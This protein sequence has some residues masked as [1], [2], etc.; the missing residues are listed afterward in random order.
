MVQVEIIRVGAL[1]TNCYVVYSD[2]SAGCVLIDPGG[3]AELISEFM[4]RQEL[5]PERIIS[6]HAHAD[7][8]GAVA[9]LV[10]RYQCKFGLGA[11]D[12]VAAGN[13]SEWLID[14]L[15]DFEEPPPPSAKY[16]G[17]ETLQCD[18]FEINVLATPGHTPGSI[19]LLIDD[20]VFTGDSL[21]RE[22]IGRFDL[23][24]G[25]Q[26]QELSSIH[27]MLLTLADETVVFPGHGPSTTIGHERFA[28]PYLQ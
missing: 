10:T 11:A 13:Q 27:T 22:S 7:H 3:E 24:G 8:T 9:P 19:S 5:T 12:A 28:N 21:F 17:G 25:S 2:G 26:E 15:G 23:P 20:L 16:F 1:S 6:T 4:E 18:G 14:M